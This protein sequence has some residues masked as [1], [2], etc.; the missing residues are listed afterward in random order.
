MIS[1]LYRILVENQITPG[2]TESLRPEYSTSQINLRTEIPTLTHLRSRLGRYLF[3]LILLIVSSVSCVV[4][5]PR[6]ATG[7][8][9]NPGVSSK[10]IKIRRICETDIRWKIIFSFCNYN[11]CG[12]DLNRDGVLDPE[13]CYP[14]KGAVFYDEEGRIVDVDIYPV[15]N[16]YSPLTERSLQ[17]FPCK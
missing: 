11:V 9:G 15:L 7:V 17:P 6:I 12:C 1:R 4:I 2:S 10:P 14:V 13:V 16:D 8:T 3:P 5:D